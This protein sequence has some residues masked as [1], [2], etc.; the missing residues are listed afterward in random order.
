[1]ANEKERSQAL[2][3]ALAQIERQFGKGAV[4][5]LGAAG[6]LEEAPVIPT[7]AIGLDVALGTGGIPRGRVTEIFGPESSGKTTLA[8]HVIAEAQRLGGSR[9]S[10]MPSTLSTPHIPRSSG[11]TPTSF[12]F[13]SRTRVNR[14][15]RLP[16]SW[17]GATRWT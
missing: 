4:M 3:L 13:H 16:R 12:L 8:L 10:S 11:S 17:C 6:A 15:W 5:R 9:H 7:G 1:M 2:E 14:P